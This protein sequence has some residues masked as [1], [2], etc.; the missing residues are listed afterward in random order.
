MA[1]LKRR[2]GYK[3][4][5]VFCTLCIQIENW[6]RFSIISNC[7]LIGCSS[8]TFS[9]QLT[10]RVFVTW[11]VISKEIEPTETVELCFG[12]PDSQFILCQLT[13]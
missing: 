5:M 7:S 4:I 9:A 2:V 10:V 1:D 8:T 11:R 13:R 12:I 3:I 6:N